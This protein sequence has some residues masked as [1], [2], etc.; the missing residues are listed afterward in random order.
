MDLAS[1]Q[2]PACTEPEVGADKAINKLLLE[3]SALYFADLL[4]NTVDFTKGFC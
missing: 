4:S 2:T 1:S 3:I